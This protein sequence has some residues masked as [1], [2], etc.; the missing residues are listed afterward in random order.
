MT[1]SLKGKVFTTDDNF[2]NRTLVIMPR[3]LEL[4]NLKIFKG[5]EE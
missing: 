1:I 4:S 2:D 5:D 3:G